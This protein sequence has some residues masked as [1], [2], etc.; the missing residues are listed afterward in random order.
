MA[1]GTEAAV[2]SYLECTLKLSKRVINIQIS[3]PH[4]RNRGLIDTGCGRSSDLR[5]DC[6]I[7]P[8]AELFKTTAVESRNTVQMNLFAG[9][10]QECRHKEANVST[11]QQRNEMGDWN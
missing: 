6:T 3:G 2:I 11:G 4:P 5:L 9:K 7:N 1:R 8:S 10:E